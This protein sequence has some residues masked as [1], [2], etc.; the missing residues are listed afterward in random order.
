MLVELV[1]VG[2]GFG[3]EFGFFGVVEVFD[4]QVVVGMQC[5]LGGVGDIECCDYIEVD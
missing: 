5:L 2:F 4:L 3:F 1:W